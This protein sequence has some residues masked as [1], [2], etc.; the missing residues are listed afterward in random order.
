MNIASIKARAPCIVN[1]EPTKAEVLAVQLNPQLSQ[2]DN[3]SEILKGQ[4]LYKWGIHRTFEL[5][6]ISQK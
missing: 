3:K 4:S 1:N 5:N 6:P 2:I